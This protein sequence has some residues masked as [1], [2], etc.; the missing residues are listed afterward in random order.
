MPAMTTRPA[1]ARHFRSL[2]PAALG[3]LLAGVG[4]AAA[5][6]AP[7]APR[8]PAAPAAPAADAPP[9]G[10]RPAPAPAAD[11]QETLPVTVRPAPRDEGWVTHHEAIVKAAAE[12]HPRLVFLGDSITEGWAGAGQAA[13]SATWGAEHPLNAGIG[14]DRTEHVLWRLDHGLL[15]A[16]SGEGARTRVIVLMIG[17]NNSNGEDATGDEIGA[18]IVAVVQRLRAGLPD[19]R[20][21]LLDIF[22]RGEKPSP[23]REKNAR[24]SAVAAAACAGDRHVTHLDIGPAFLTPDGTLT[25]E[26]MPDRLHLSPD[27][28]AI[29]SRAIAP[30]VA[31]L[32]GPEPAR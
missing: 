25:A 10:T 8:E 7:A 18:G 13:W 17:T 27:G 30:T 32:L 29:W 21:V 3:A 22:P 24:A 14:G 4:S 6:D 12:T 9:T 5:Q 20:I 26:I 16:L 31:E 28:Y 19:A 11:L 15:A 23:Q 1:P 2:L